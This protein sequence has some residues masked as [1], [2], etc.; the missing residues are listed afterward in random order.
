VVIA[1]RWNGKIWRTMDIQ[2]PGGIDWSTPIDVACA[3]ASSCIAVGSRKSVAVTWQLV[4]RT[5][6]LRPAAAEPGPG[7]GLASVACP[8]ANRCTAVGFENT[9]HSYRKRPLIER[10]NGTRWNRLAPIPTG[11]HRIPSDSY[12]LGVDCTRPRTCV[13]V[14]TDGY[15]CGPLALNQY[16]GSVWTFHRLPGEYVDNCLPLQNISCSTFAQ[17]AAVGIG[18][19]RGGLYHAGTAWRDATSPGFTI[20][21]TTGPFF[22]DVACPTRT[23]LYVGSDNHNNESETIPHQPVIYSGGAT[24]SQQVI[25]PAPMP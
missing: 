6:E 19:D 14:G 3:G 10:W 5:L 2:H 22:D 8:S 21:R 17:C 25:P 24:P 11:A 16:R 9:L 15:T 18:F 7:A 13:A 20:T 12:L 1:E 4:G 23:C